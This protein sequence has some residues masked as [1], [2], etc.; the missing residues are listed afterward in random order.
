MP[1]PELPGLSALLVQGGDERI[2]LQGESGQN[3]YGVSPAPR[4]G[5]V[6]FSS[7][8]ASHIS[9][10]AWAA[11]DAFRQRMHEER[12]DGP[13]HE[14]AL[15]QREARRIRTTFCTTWGLEAAQMSWHLHRS[16]TD[17]HAMASALSLRKFGRPYRIVMGEACETG[18]KV[19]QA[20]LEGSRQQGRLM[21]ELSEIAI[22]GEDGACR[23]AQAIDQD[24]LRVV[25]QSLAEDVPVMVVR[26]DESK[27]G[28]CYPSQALVQQIAAGSP[29]H[30]SVL[31][32]CSQLR[33]E[34][35]VLQDY[36]ARQ[37]LVVL[38]GSKFYGAPAFCGALL[39]GADWAA[40]WPQDLPDVDAHG[41]PNFGVLA[42]WEAALC[43]MQRYQQLPDEVRHEWLACFEE[44]LTQRVAASSS[45]SL[46]DALR[47]GRSGPRS[48]FALRCRDS[49][50]QRSLSPAEVE[51]VYRRLNQM[52]PQQAQ[53]YV[54]AIGQPVPCMGADG[55]RSQYLRLS[56]SAPM[57]LMLAQMPQ[58]QG[59]AWLRAR[60]DGVV[61]GLEE[62][63][64][65]LGQSDR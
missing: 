35:Q 4:A 42:R 52:Q 51:R 53:E 62:E 21:A 25:T 61:G 24:F 31:V 39:G 56:L 48:L 46:L 9:A 49:G 32:D 13:E 45:L 8:T 20:L 6:E 37:Y 34:A 47:D 27:S 12:S 54:Y 17:A 19:A 16:G 3:K 33:C 44:A 11:V 57:L 36:L 55:Q 30:T 40:V 5:L 50:G 23:S 58:A 10:E 2:A 18:S 14:R 29:Q 41:R 64:A 28:C 1:M 60:I 63:I 7:S 59:R 43:A 26:V 15:W 22:R 65:L 38:T